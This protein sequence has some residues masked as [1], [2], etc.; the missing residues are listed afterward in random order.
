M[1]IQL[2]DL[3]NLDPEK[4]D[5]GEHCK[6][7]DSSCMEKKKRQLLFEV[8]EAENDRRDLNYAIFDLSILTERDTK[9]IRSC[10][11]RLVNRIRLVIQTSQVEEK[12]DMFKSKLRI[13]CEEF[14]QIVDDRV[15]PY[16]WVSIYVK[17]NLLRLKADF[18]RY[19]F[20]IHPQNGNY[21]VRAHNAYTEAKLFFTTHRMTKTSEW[22][23]SRLNYA[24]LLYL[25]G[26]PTAALFICQQ[27]LKPS[28]TKAFD[29]VF[30]KRIR[31]NVDFFKRATL[32]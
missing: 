11:E 19:L 1:D 21:Q 5:H 25:D 30:E 22:Y 10:Y 17:G 3:R 23:R 14:I 4:T 16:Y 24:T 7:S 29:S 32:S 27:L 13:Y 8:T 28:K 2:I 31:K 26:F 6:V 20:E 18:L 12:R 15:K 9:K